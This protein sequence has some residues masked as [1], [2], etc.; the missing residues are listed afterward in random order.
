VC[1]VLLGIIGC[2]PPSPPQTACTFRES[3]PPPPTAAAAPVT[4]MVVFSVITDSS[5]RCHMLTKESSLV[6]RVARAQHGAGDEGLAH[7]AHH[8]IGGH[9]LRATR[10]QPH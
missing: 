10:V 6:C 8:V 9:L 2:P 5:K 7:I 3:T 4:K 1:D